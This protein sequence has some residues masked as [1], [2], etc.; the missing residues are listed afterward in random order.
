[1]A[2]FTFGDLV[3]TTADAPPIARPR[4]VASVCGMTA[5]PRRDFPP[6]TIYLVEF[7]DGEAIEVHE[8]FLQA[9]PLRRFWIQF[10]QGDPNVP[11]SLRLGCG[12]TAWTRD[13]AL[14]LLK[15]HVGDLV[16][17]IVTENV[18]VST[19]DPRH[20]L[21]NMAAPNVRGIWYPIGYQRN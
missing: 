12:V 21:P 17:R 14:F 16:I 2:I 18:D 9:M 11:S 4:N 13:D 3:E 8:S 10:D 7:P 19:L 6:G 15:R 5:G 1:M 20:I